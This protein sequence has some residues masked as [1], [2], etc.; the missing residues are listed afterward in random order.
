MEEH[1]EITVEVEELFDDDEEVID[2]D[3][4]KKRASMAVGLISQWRG[5]RYHRA[6]WPVRSRGRR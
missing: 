2:A 5:P 6:P 1:E 3:K 4:P